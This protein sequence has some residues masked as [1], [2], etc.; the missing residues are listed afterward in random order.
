MDL[1]GPFFGLLAGA[2]FG[3]NVHIQRMAL[4][5]VDALTGSFISVAA[6]AALFWVV[7]PFFIEWHWWGTQTVLI[8]AACGLIFPAMGQRLQIASVQNVGPAMTS[9]IGSFVPVFAVMPAVWFLGETFGLQPSIGLG[10]MLIGL[11]TA[12][13]G[14]KGITRD[15][16]VWML[17]LP[18][19]AAAVRGIA[20]PTIGLGL[21]QLPSPVF[22]TLVLSTV[23]TV[24]LGVMVFFSKPKP[25]SGDP[26]IGRNW[27]ILGGFINGAGILS[28]NV[29]IYLGGV[30][31]SAPMIATAPLWALLFGVLIFKRERLEK[32]HAFI[33][34]IVTIGA[35]LI[36][37]R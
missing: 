9:A 11:V 5:G 34:L 32:R 18:L 21:S 14:R 31:L 35:M 4:D 24:V 16:P 22:A 23:S 13:L 30:T 15:W 10:L 29:G 27:F 19:G 7:A 36:V 12:S 3:F 33:G 20:Q 2:L 1:L 28:L 8:F 6:M 26:V 37:S 25:K 17:L